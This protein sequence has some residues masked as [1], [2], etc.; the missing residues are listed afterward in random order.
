[1][2]ATG[3]QCERCWWQKSELSEWQRSADEEG[4]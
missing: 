1:M 3:E 2:K 4:F